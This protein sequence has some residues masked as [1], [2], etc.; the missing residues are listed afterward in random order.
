MKQY[1]KWGEKK[2][3]VEVPEGYV[4]LSYEARLRDR[5]RYFNLHTGAW[6]WVES[7]D[8]GMLVGP[9]GVIACRLSHPE[10]AY[11]EEFDSRTEFHTAEKLV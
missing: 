8:I 4:F 9:L 3:R 6:D 10:Q 11:Q 5:D 7:D 2:R 1:V